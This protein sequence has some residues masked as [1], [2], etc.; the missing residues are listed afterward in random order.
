MPHAPP[1]QEVAAFGKVI[2]PVEQQT[3]GTLPGTAF[4]RARYPNALKSG[5]QETTVV[6]LSLRKDHRER[7][8]VTITNQMYF[9]GQATSAFPDA[10]F[11][12]ITRWRASA[13]APFFAGAFLAP[14]AWGCTLMLVLS[15]AQAPQATS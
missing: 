5:F 6:T 7:T 15:A 2:A 10:F 11:W 12:G 13:T 3:C 14:A 1:P 4:A 9:R 8:T